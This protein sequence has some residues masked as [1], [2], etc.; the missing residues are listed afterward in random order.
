MRDGPIRDMR[1][2]ALHPQIDAA[3]HSLVGTAS[4]TVLDVIL[5]NI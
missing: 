2:A 4:T 3:R 1:Q 5:V